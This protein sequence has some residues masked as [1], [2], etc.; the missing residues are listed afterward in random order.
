[1]CVPFLVGCPQSLVH[2][3]K[4]HDP[5]SAITFPVERY[6][7]ASLTAHLRC[8]E[9]AFLWLFLARPNILKDGMS[10]EVCIF[11]SSGIKGFLNVV[12][13]IYS[14]RLVYTLS[15]ST[16]FLFLSGCVGTLVKSIKFSS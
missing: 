3:D 9:G 13:S 5:L 7:A 12:L 2:S 6:L 15:P 8:L 11:C 14:L 4:G 1:M 10:H 16:V